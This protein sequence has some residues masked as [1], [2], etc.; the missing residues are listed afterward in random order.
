MA[1]LYSHELPRALAALAVGV[2][3]RDL[4]E[5][6]ISYACVPGSRMVGQ[7]HVVEVFNQFKRNFMMIVLETEA[8]KMNFLSNY[9]T[10]SKTLDLTLVV[11]FTNVKMEY[12]VNLKH[13]YDL[14]ISGTRITKEDMT[15]LLES[16]NRRLAENEG[17]TI[18]NVSLKLSN[19]GYDKKLTSHIQQ[20]AGLFNNFT[21]IIFTSIDTEINLM[22]LGQLEHLEPICHKF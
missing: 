6:N 14:T 21:K 16:C 8:H 20:L 9:C 7:N 22:E 2:L 18:T 5:H 4:C 10:T 3:V 19:I 15:V 17:T 12:L 11:Y 1:Q 13:L